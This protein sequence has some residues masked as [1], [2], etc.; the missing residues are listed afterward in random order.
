[1]QKQSEKVRRGWSN[2]FGPQDEHVVNT[3]TH[4]VISKAWY[5]EE[6]CQYRQGGLHT[7]EHLSEATAL[8]A[9]AGKGSSAHDAMW[10]TTQ[11]V[12]LFGI[13]LG[14]LHQLSKD[15]NKRR[16]IQIS[17]SCKPLNQAHP[18]YIMFNWRRNKEKI[19]I[20]F[21]R[22]LASNANDG[23]LIKG[24]IIAKTFKRSIEGSQIKVS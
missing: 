7:R 20:V 10:V 9:E 2:V 18:H 17:L 21:S 6:S 12:V 8:C 13:Q 5:H 14:R 3:S 24:S 16:L 11:D 23:V 22:V 1:M 4:C 15:R 19:L